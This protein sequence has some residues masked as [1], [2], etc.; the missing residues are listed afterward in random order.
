MRISDLARRAGLTPATIR[1][2]ERLGLLPAP[3]RSATGYRLYDDELADRLRFIKA[4]QRF[5]LRLNE[6]GELL[7]VQ[8]RGRCPCGHTQELLRKRV[9]EVDEELSRLIQLRSE[10]V[11]MIE[12]ADCSAPASMSWACAAEFIEGRCDCDNECCSV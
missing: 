2:Y 3:A 7:E 4:A 1:Y 8:D 9:A 12:R 6:I 11:E 10:L 5:G